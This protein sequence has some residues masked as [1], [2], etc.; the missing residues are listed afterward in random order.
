MVSRSSTELEYKAL[1]DLAAK[2]T[3]IKSLL[4]ELKFLMPRK[5]VLWID[6][7]SAKVLTSNPVM[8]ARSKHIEI[9]VH[10][11]RDQV[12]QNQVTI[13]YV[14]T[15]DQIANCLT[16]PLTHKGQHFERQTRDD[17]VTSV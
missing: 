1:A 13:A 11:I 16:K 6:N 17:R 12:L 15:T 10:Y 8:H 3:W 14:P 5:P 7:L 2:V 9:N 4:D